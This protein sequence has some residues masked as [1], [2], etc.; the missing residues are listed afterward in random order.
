MSHEE[1]IDHNFAFS[2]EKVLA[3]A[4]SV[5]QNCNCWNSPELD[6]G[7]TVSRSKPGALRPVRHEVPPPPRLP[8]G[9]VA[10]MGPS[11]VTSQAQ[12]VVWQGPSRAHC[13]EN[14]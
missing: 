4:L 10:V 5:F 3:G 11:A 6:S 8:E 2:N 14:P 9:H 7:S 1:L 12:R 13:T